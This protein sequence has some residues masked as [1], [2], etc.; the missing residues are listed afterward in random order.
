MCPARSLRIVAGSKRC[1]LDNGARNPQVFGSVARGDAAQGS[2]L[3]L[4]VELDASGGNPPLRV[5]GLS[6]E[7][8]ELLGLHVDVV[9]DELLREP[10]AAGETRW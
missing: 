4:L 1:S 9:T 2:D 3:D 6:E 5:A 10:A 7:L 8:S